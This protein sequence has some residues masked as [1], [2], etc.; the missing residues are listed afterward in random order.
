MGLKSFL[1][2]NWFYYKGWFPHIPIALFVGFLGLIR[3]A[4]AVHNFL[5]IP[6]TGLEILNMR[7]VIFD[8]SLYG[9]PQGFLGVFLILISIGLFYRL[10]TSWIMAI[11]LTTAMLILELLPNVNGIQIHWSIYNII[12]LLVLALSF[13]SFNRSSIAGASLVAMTFF[14]LVLGYAI[15]G[16]F[17]LGQGFNPPIQDIVTAFYFAIVT[18]ATVGYGDILPVT[19]EARL[20]VVSMI[21]AGFLIIATVVSTVLIPLLKERLYAIFRPKGGKMKRLKHFIIIGDTPLVHNSVAEFSR[22]N[23][24]VTLI[25]SQAPEEQHPLQDKDFVIGDASNVET[26]RE[27]GGE[28]ALAILALTSDDAYNAFIVLAARELPGEFKTVAV[29]ND[30]K[31]MARIQRVRPDAILAPQVIGGE[32][33]AIAFSG[34]KPDS[35]GLINKLLNF[36]S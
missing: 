9:I 14:I 35:E 4:L 34:E 24:P 32:L 12:T 17:I 28:K 8:Q 27:A 30:A 25:L 33:L 2:K 1:K 7:D 20:F 11:L 23:L 18:M 6:L 3:V 10:R 21:V 26:L 29:V 22:R 19:L 13:R 5:G 31:N 15:L 36:Q 16:S